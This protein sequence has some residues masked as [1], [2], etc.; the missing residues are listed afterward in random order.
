M[1]T[2]NI[3][4][5]S[6]ELGNDD[7]YSNSFFLPSNLITRGVLRD[8]LPWIYHTFKKMGGEIMLDPIYNASYSQD[9]S[10][11]FIIDVKNIGLQNWKLA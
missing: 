10:I 7:Y 1:H 2:F 11:N 8:N 9:L 4:S 6:P 3:P 5:V